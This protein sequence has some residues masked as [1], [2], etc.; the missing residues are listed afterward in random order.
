[1]VV[2]ARVVRFSLFRDV[3]SPGSGSGP[4]DLREKMLSSPFELVICGVFPIRVW[5][6]NLLD[7]WLIELG[8]WG[9]SVTSVARQVCGS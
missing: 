6:Q 9:C 8:F 2:R 3:V 5:E 7:S 1:M 4:V